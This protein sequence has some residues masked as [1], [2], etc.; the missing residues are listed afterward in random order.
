[1]QSEIY[2]DVTLDQVC[3]YRCLQVR[4]FDFKAVN[5]KPGAVIY[6][7]PIDPEDNWIPEPP[8]EVELT[9]LKEFKLK[10]TA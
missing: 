1:M 3:I 9:D 8:M 5:R 4:I 2:M 6:W 10:K 7:E